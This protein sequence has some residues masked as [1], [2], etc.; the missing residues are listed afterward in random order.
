MFAKLLCRFHFRDSILN[1]SKFLFNFNSPTC[2]F[3]FWISN[4]KFSIYLHASYFYLTNLPYYEYY[5]R[6]PKNL[7][8][9]QNGR[10]RRNGGLNDPR[11]FL[12]AEEGQPRRLRREV[13]L[14]TE[15]RNL[16]VKAL[17]RD[18]PVREVPDFMQ[19]AGLG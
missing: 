8:G 2:Y 13:V 9:P 16:R 6:I 10:L 19:W 12:R 5:T 15:D 18:V 3:R 4:L 14:L 7:S 1:N 11:I 17:A